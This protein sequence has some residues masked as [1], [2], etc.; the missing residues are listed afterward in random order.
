[1]ACGSNSSTLNHCVGDEPANCL[2]AAATVASLRRQRISSAMSERRCAGKGV[3]DERFM[4]VSLQLGECGGQGNQG[5]LQILRPDAALR[6]VLCRGPTFRTSTRPRR[7]WDG[8]K[9]NGPV[10]VDQLTAELGEQP[11]RRRRIQA[12]PQLSPCRARPANEGLGA[13]RPRQW[14]MTCGLPCPRNQYRCGQHPQFGLGLGKP[15]ES[16]ASRTFL[17]QFSLL[18]AM[19]SRSTGVQKRDIACLTLPWSATAIRVPS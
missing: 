19:K 11:S 16:A 13:A 17:H 14:P 6:R 2:R 15:L 18:H 8:G 1:M 12:T 7:R 5:V 3:L 10:S 9:S 4:R